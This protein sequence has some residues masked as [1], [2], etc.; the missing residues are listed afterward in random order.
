M[1]IFSSGLGK[2]LLARFPMGPNFKIEIGSEMADFGMLG[3]VGFDAE[4][5]EFW[6]TFASIVHWPVRHA[7]TLVCVVKAAYR[8]IL[9]CEFVI[10]TRF[11]RV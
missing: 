3:R 8:A 10:R 7:G 11:V 1:S 5:L 6:K 2:L 9:I 4:F